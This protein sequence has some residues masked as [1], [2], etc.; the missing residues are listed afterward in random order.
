[1]NLYKHLLFLYKMRPL[2][3]ILWPWLFLTL[4]GMLYCVTGFSQVQGQAAID[5][6]RRVLPAAKSDTDH[7]NI[8]LRIGNNFSTINPDSGLTYCNQ[9]LLMAKTAGWEK[10][11]GNAYNILGICQIIKS[12]YTAAISSWNTALRIFKSI[13]DKRD[14]L[15]VIGNLGGIYQYQGDYP[16]ALQHY[17]EALKYAEDLGDKRS[18][19]INK[20]NIGTAYEELGQYNKALQYYEEAV[21]ICQELGMLQFHASYLGNIGIIYRDKQQYGKALQCLDSSLSE[22][23]KLGNTEGILRDIVNIGVIYEQQHDY[24]TALDYYFKVL[25]QAR[26]V[27]MK[28]AE[29]KAL[30]SIGNVL[31][32]LGRLPADSISAQMHTVLNKYNIAPTKQQ[33]LQSA[34]SYYRQSIALDSAAGDLKILHQTYYVLS[35][36]EQLSGNTA[37]A[38]ESYKQYTRFKDSVMS[39]ESKLKI[40]NLETQRELELKDKQIIIDKLEVAKKRNERL[41]FIAGIVL[42]LAVVI[43]VIR[44]I[45]LSTAKE[46][47]ENKL[48][49]FQARMNPHFIFNSLSSIQ[50]LIMN[51]EKEQSIDYLS[52]FSILMR[53]ILDNSGQS[54]VTLKTEIDM[55]RSY[56]E[57]ERLRFGNFQHSIY[58]APDIIEETVEVPGMIIQP[59]VENAIL[60][61]IMSK[62]EKG[63]L[64]ISFTRDDKHIICT[65]EDNG[66]GREAAG[67]IKAKKPNRRQSHGTSIA[68]NRLTLLNDKKRGL[69]NKVI[70]IDKI[71]N[72]IAAGTKVIIELPKL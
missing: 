51:D 5:S 31:L 21:K 67:G 47:S 69:V 13:D 35:E 12:D 23:E 57:L 8:L 7:I 10:G 61:G 71:E 2:R 48:N 9:A 63:S 36:A 45:R 28:M 68:I 70:Y 22:N 6:L 15:K 18:V 16:H 33:L 46:L 64:N 40:T 34:I 29:S 44:N 30:L 32:A 3:S 19:A 24:N 27:N 56:I 41:F 52:E 58:I 59:F 1:M 39:T 54:K 42:L 38:F 26:E 65:V 60:H 53:Q 17:F 66:I 49:A 37:A 11:I 25:R 43:I 55:L 72:G 20:G 4:S 14:M 50:S 62:G